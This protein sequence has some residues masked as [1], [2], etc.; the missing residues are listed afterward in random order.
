MSIRG[1]ALNTGSQRCAN[2]AM[3]RGQSRRIDVGIE[4]LRSL[5]LER[6]GRTDLASS[7]QP[8]Y[9]FY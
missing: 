8:K 2:R 4:L 6:T 7:M 9:L 1:L 3:V 5:P